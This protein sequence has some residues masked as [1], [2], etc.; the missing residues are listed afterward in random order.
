M[1]G[2]R[3]LVSMIGRFAIAAAT[4]GTLVAC[5]MAV[6]QQLP[7]TGRVSGAF[8]RE[9]GPLGAGGKQPPVVRLRGVITFTAAHRRTVRAQT[10]KR[11]WFSVALAPGEYS[12]YGKSPSIRQVGPSGRGPG[13]EVRCSQPYTVRVTSRHI[14]KIKVV[15]AVP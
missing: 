8:V 11:G 9:G 6:G 2:Q 14:D 1:A 12:V 13:H 4:A 15:C 7:A 3:R 5:T 10:N